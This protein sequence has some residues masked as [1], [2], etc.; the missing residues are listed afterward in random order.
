MK[1]YKA[2]AAALVS[3]GLD[4]LLAVKLIEEQ[5]IFVQGLFFETPFFG[6]KSV[7]KNCAANNINLKIIPC[8]DEYK[9][10]L[11]NPATGYGKHMNPCIDCHAFMLR[12]AAKFIHENKERKVP[13]TS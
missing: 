8:F 11:L 6:L 2:K 4:S 7:R 3:G 5:N 1:N 10:M 13:Q 12:K 9:H